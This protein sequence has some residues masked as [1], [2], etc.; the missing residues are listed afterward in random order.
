[1]ISKLLRGWAAA[2]AM[3][4][5]SAS[6]HA[7]PFH[8]LTGAGDADPTAPITAAGHTPVGLADL[9]AGDL[10]G[11]SVLWITNGDNGGLP[12]AFVG[13][14]AA[15]AAWVS[16]GGVLSFHDRYVSDGSDDLA[17]LLPGAAGA[18]FV[19]DFANDADIDILAPLH[20]VVAGLDD[21]SLDGGTS[22][23]HGYVELATLPA[24]ATAVL[25]RGGAIDEIVDFYY[26]FGAG[27][28]YYSTMPLDYYLGGSG[29]NPPQDNYTDIY[30]VNEAAF[31]ASLAGGSV[32]EPA[33]TALLG[34]GLA[35]FGLRRRARRV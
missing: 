13:N 2:A 20:P 33:T 17:S 15:V 6:A 22:S 9:T 27:W 7:I 35:A 29:G 25:N 23:S 18:V 4:L 34:L 12:A 11:V 19:R 10:A 14:A 8:Y 24:G 1:M 21:T 26:A 5:A 3:V 32:P 28:V 16:A 31:Q 30:A